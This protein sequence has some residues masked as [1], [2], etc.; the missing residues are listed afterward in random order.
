MA[1]FRAGDTPADGHAPRIVDPAGLGN[2]AGPDAWVPGDG[3]PLFGA[4]RP[5]AIGGGARNL[6]GRNERLDVLLPRDHARTPARLVLLSPDADAAE[7][8]IDVGH[9]LPALPLARDPVPAAGT[10]VT[11]LG[12][13]G[14]PPGPLGGQHRPGEPDGEAPHLVSLGGTIAP[15][16]DP[17]GGTPS[18]A[19]EGLFRVSTGVAGGPD[20]GPVLGADGAVLGVVASGLPGQ[21]RT[22]SAFAAKAARTLLESR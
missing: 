10:P 3:G 21:E 7:L 4:R 16:P 17:A 11:V 18:G 13:V 22:L 6:E 9:P 20:G 5:V 8:R 15:A 12:Y 2:G 14:A 1:L 19:A